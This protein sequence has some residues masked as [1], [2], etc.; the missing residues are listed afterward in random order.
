[1]R[2]KNGI[3]KEYDLVTW[4]INLVVAIGDMEKEINQKYAPQDEKYDWIGEPCATGATT[5]NV[6]SKNEKHMCSLVW[7]PKKENCVGSIIAHEAGHV[8]MEIFH[9]TGSFI[10]YDNQEPFCYLLGNIARL[11]I[12]TLYELPGIKSPKFKE[13]KRKKQTKEENGK[14][15]DS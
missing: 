8:A 14:T 6:Y 10:H 11:I 1:M 15:S 7:F 2:N 4:P 9:Y 5:Y 13:E 3:L 12:G